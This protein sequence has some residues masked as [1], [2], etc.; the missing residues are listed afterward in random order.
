MDNRADATTLNRATNSLG[1]KNW[2]PVEVPCASKFGGW[3][4][5]LDAA[6]SCLSFEE[7]VITIVSRIGRTSG[8][9]IEMDRAVG[10]IVVG[11]D[12]ALADLM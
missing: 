5:A 9:S 3:S 1:D 7:S 10:S 4:V 12:D 6:S 2:A 11:P 8:V